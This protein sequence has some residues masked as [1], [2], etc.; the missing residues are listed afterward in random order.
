MNSIVCKPTLIL[1][2]SLSAPA[3]SQSKGVDFMAYQ[4]GQQMAQDQHQAQQEF[5]RQQ[6][7]AEM[8]RQEYIQGN[9]SADEQRAETFLT[10]VLQYRAEAIEKGIPMEEFWRVMRNHILN[11]PGFLGMPMHAQM[12]TMQKLEALYK[13][14]DGRM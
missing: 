4:R 2:M 5:Q 13:M 9:S 8:Q 3:Y 6:M 1:L 10:P 7:L 12:L 14:T 11:D